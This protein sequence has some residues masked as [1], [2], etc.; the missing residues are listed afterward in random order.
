MLFSSSNILKLLNKNLK[1]LAIQCL[2]ID[3]SIYTSE[4]LI[5]MQNIISQLT[6]FKDVGTIVTVKK[7]IGK[8]K[9]KYI[10]QSGHANDKDTNYCETCGKNIK[11]LTIDETGIIERFIIKTESLQLLINKNYE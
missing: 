1:S 4:D 5:Q 10:C 7:T 2:D 9:E 6:K 11:G 3:K 8:A